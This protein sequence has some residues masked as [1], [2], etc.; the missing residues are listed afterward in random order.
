MQESLGRREAAAKA[1]EHVGAAPRTGV[2]GTDANR[3]QAAQTIMGK[4]HAPAA[5]P[6]NKVE[7][8]NE[9]GGAAGTRPA[10]AVQP[11]D[12]SKAGSSQLDRASQTDGQGLPRL[13]TGVAIGG[14]EEVRSMR[15][16]DLS[17]RLPLPE[18]KPNKSS[19]LMF[20]K[21]SKP[22]RG[23]TTEVRGRCL[24]PSGWQS[25]AAV[26]VAEGLPSV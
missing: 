1:E 23:G 17:I 4:Q 7:N 9:G 24:K 5:S 13:A 3:Q 19:R 6:G 18:A 22:R 26:S 16:P 10:H 15:G 8:A 12:R 2:R 25:C 14:A 21:S 11:W 20:W